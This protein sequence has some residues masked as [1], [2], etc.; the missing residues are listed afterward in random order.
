MT[1]TSHCGLGEPALVSLNSDDSPHTLC[2]IYPVIRGMS[3]LVL[4]AAL[5]LCDLINVLGETVKVLLLLLELLLE[6]NE[7]LLL[8]LADSVIFAGLLTSLESITRT[9]GSAGSSSSTLRHDARSGREA[10]NGSEGSCLTERCAKH[11]CELDLVSYC[12][13]LGAKDQ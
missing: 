3:C 10:S 9:S 13:L 6:L 11:G 4:L 7:L 1:V 2:L 8:T 5:L 12:Y